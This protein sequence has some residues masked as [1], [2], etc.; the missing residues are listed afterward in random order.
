MM[1]RPNCLTCQMH[2]SDGKWQ[3]AIDCVE[4]IHAEARQL[5]EDIAAWGGSLAFSPFPQDLEMRQMAYLDRERVT[6]VPPPED[7]MPEAIII[8][9]D[10]F[11]VMTNLRVQCESVATAQADEDNY[12]V[13]PKAWRITVHT[14]GTVVRQRCPLHV[15]VP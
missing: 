15:E 1:D 5:I 6:R 4:D 12:Y 10:H 3:H 13:P 9:C 7:G 2:Q 14:D 8:R 11:E